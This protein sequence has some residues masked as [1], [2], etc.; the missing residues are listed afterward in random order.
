MSHVLSAHWNFEFPFK[1]TYISLKSLFG[2]CHYFGLLLSL[3]GKWHKNCET[4]ISFVMS[5]CTIQPRSRWTDFCDI[6]YWG[7]ILKSVVIIQF[8]LKTDED[9]NAF[10]FF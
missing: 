8:A 1:C 9:P 5:V 10:I 3:L 4:S 6:L 2:R 7:V